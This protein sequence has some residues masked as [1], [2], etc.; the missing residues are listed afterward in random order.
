VQKF[1]AIEKVIAEFK[2]KHGRVPSFWLDKVC[3]DQSKI[4]EALRALPIFLVSCKAMLIVAGPTY[5]HRLWC[6]WEVHMLFVVSGGAKPMLE[7]ESIR[8]EFWR[9]GSD[10]C[11]AE[12]I[13]AFTL[14]EARC[15]D[16]NEERRLRA[17][18]AA[19]PGGAA[20][21]ESKIR[22]IADGLKRISVPCA[23]PAPVQETRLALDSGISSSGAL[24]NDDAADAYL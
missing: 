15:Y 24:D 11:L 6:I 5:V 1:A 20:V 4:T 19:A 8:G 16:P 22:G 9:S 3:I 17:A 23:R 2:R 14:D 18:I 7:V 10:P 12:K 21:F 13:A